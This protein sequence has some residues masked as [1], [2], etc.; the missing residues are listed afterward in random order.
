MR[1]ASIGTSVCAISSDASNATMIV[2]A[3]WVR[4]IVMSVWAPNMIGANTM[5]VVAVPAMTARPTSRTP[6]SVDWCG[7]PGFS[8]RCLKML[9]VT[10]TALSTSMPTASMS[11]IIERMLSVRPAKY[12]APSV[13]MSE[14]GTEAVTISVV[15]T[16]RRNRYSTISASRP[17]SAPAP[18]KSD[19]DSRTLSP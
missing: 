11:P 15:E 7:S 6:S 13:I 10:T 9:S 19:S 5:I 12:I 2:I 8:L 14:N 18:S 3:T 16:C 17:P 1:A 4:K